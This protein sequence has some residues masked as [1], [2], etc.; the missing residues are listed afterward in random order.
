MKHVLVLGATGMLGAY[1]ALALKSA[2]YRVSAVSRRL[3]DNGFFAANDIPYTGGW[4]LADP[5]TFDRLPT[6]IDAVV[7]M[8]GF[9]PAH[10]DASVLP[11]V[12]SIVEG[13][14]NVCEW[15]RTRTQ[16]R[17]IVFNTTPADVA[18]H[19]GGSAPIP[20]NAP[21][22]WPRDGGDHAP[23]A[24]CK[25]AA[26]DLLG[27][28]Q[29]ACGFRPVVFRHMT[30]FGWHPDA[31]FNVNGRSTVS[32]WRQVL[33][34]CIAGHPI[35]IWGNPKRRSELL[36]I[37]DFTA[38]VRAAIESD[39]IG[40]FNL[41]GPRPYTLEE[42]FSALQNVF[43]IGT[44]YAGGGGRLGSCTGRNCPSP[45]NACSTEPSPEGT[46]LAGGGRM[47]GSLPADPARN[48]R[49]PICPAVGRGGGG[50]PSAPWPA[51]GLRAA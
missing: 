13:T 41:P 23:Y 3:S 44:N 24:V 35:E 46:R 32:P 33:R 16:C 6:G 51:C 11:Y 20:D 19:R 42:E 27:V 40:L 7:H 31:S 36:Y 39:A 43:R 29:I 8:A 30:V 1:S 12:K 50:G 47:A 14:A 45:P 17:R 34:R 5:A 22:S 18:A 15:M 10:G 21:R 25:I 2:G 48:G 49:Q 28:Y 9:M 37:D 26:T 4:D 38:A